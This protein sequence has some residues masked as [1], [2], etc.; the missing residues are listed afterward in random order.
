M[1]LRFLSG[2]YRWVQFAIV[3][4][5]LGTGMLL[6]QRPPTPDAH[7][8]PFAGNTS[9]IADGEVL[10]QQTCQACHGGK[11]RG[12]RGPALAGGNFR[13]GGEDGELFQTIRN[14]VPGTQMPAFSD[15]PTDNVWRIISY[16]RSLNSNGGAADEVLRGDGAAGEKTFWGKAGCGRCH[17]VNGRGGI[18][19]PDLSAA[20]TNSADYLRQMVL[21]PNAGVATKRWFGPNSY[22][23]KTRDGQEIR[24]VKL[25][26]DNFTLILTDEKGVRHRFDKRDLLELR[27]EFLMPDNYG[28]ILSAEEIQNLVAYLK[29]LKAR[30]LSKTIEADLAGGLSFE[31]LRNAQFEPQNWLTY[32]GGYQSFHFSPLSEITPGNI[33]QL[34]ARWAKQMPGSSVL[35]A[36]PL[37]VDG[38]MYTAGSPGEVYAL[39]ALTGLEIWRYERRQKVV[40]PY[41]INPFNRGV[42]VL[43]NRVFFGTLDAALVALDART[44]RVL[45]ETQVA[46]T[47]E[48]YSI[49]GA[50]MAVQGK[51][52][53]GIAGGEFGI[54]GFIDAYDAV[55][56]KRLWRFYTIPGPG[57]T[58]H[59][60]WSGDSWKRG[61]GGTWLTGSYDPELNLLYWTVGNPGPN[62]NG[63]VRK[64]DNLFTCSVVALNPETGKLTWYYQFTPGDTHDWDANEDV[65]LADRTIDGQ[66]RKL[67]MQ[68]DRNGMFYVLDRSNGKFL[69]A[70]PYVKQNWNRG[71]RPDG[72]PI[73]EPDWQASPKGSV[74][75]PT[76]VGGSN[77]QSPS[78][79]PAS[80]WLY[81]VARDHGQGYRSAPVTYEAGREYI[82]GEPYPAPEPGGEAGKN[83]VLAIDTATGDVKWKFPI[84]RGS[85]GAGVLS[86]A[87]G[88]VFAATANGDLIALDSKSGKALWHFQTGAT[89]NSSPM[90][91]AVNGK[92]FVAIAAGNV[93]YSFALPD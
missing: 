25:S 69:F 8:N 77:W 24:G 15:L 80:S 45:W 86:T 28:Q 71:F 79:D 68:A 67:I 14:G 89:I 43:E 56:G 11:A 85:F 65:I 61:S 93:L 16:L 59:D 34:G 76:G 58:G 54:R 26:E 20:G 72:S 35:E 38:T 17:E 60:T 49:T 64:G 30:D 39:D 7:K 91:Y 13:H 78:Y 27:T 87:G 48:G 37:V 53:V 82:G 10:Y 52:I 88:I 44:G 1:T 42:A 84:V 62:M 22:R 73:L 31:R 90:S 32:W 5:A 51:V 36:T 41:Q 50:P 74:V 33:G 12:D 57:E 4:S 55:T 9:A 6:A 81:V 46:D 3:G 2:Q 75:Y 70:K 63:D 66:P 83:G 29:S 18:V 21:N 23:V 40:N 92:Q 47:M 19:A